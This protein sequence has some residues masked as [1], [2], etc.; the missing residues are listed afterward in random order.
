MPLESTPSGEPQDAGD[1]GDCIAHSTEDPKTAEVSLDGA[2][3]L[4]IN[5]DVLRVQPSQ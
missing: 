2:G 3:P 4:S 1:L 5:G